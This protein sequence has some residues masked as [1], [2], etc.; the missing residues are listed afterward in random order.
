MLRNFII[1]YTN[2][3][4]APWF[5]KIAY[6]NFM[7]SIRPGEGKIGYKYLEPEPLGDRC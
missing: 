6:F 2:G 3:D 7:K 5:Q 4:S 1:T